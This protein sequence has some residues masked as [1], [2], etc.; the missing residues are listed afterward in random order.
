MSCER[1][2]YFREPLTGDLDLPV[3][4]KAL[5]ACFRRPP[6][7]NPRSRSTLTFRPNVIWQSNGRT[8][9][10]YRDDRDGRKR[11]IV[12]VHNFA[13]FAL[14]PSKQPLYQ[15]RNEEFQMTKSRTKP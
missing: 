1:S 13:L 15:L 7:P 9:H 5:A 14:E 3:R 11:K 10:L 2:M 4:K 6:E 8:F 12:V